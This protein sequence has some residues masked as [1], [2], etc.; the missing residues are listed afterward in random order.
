MNGV[1]GAIFGGLFS[2]LLFLA[3]LGLYIYLMVLVFKLAHRGIKALDI[4]ISKN[5][6]SGYTGQQ[7]NYNPQNGSPNNPNNM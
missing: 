5:S 4:Y 3:F 6:N 2:I 1:G 7:I